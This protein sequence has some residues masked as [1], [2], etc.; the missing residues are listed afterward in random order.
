MKSSLFGQQKITTNRTNKQI[1]IRYFFLFNLKILI[2]K[3][4]KKSLVVYK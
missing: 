2:K 4:R 3:K 1:I